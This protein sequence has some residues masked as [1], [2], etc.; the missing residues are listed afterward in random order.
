MGQDRRGLV[1]AR[2]N[3]SMLV[4]DISEVDKTSPAQLRREYEQQLAAA[5]DEIGFNTVAERT[6]ID[7]NTLSALQTGESPE[8]TVEEAAAIL[9]LTDAWPDAETL[10]LELRDSV[11]LRMSSAVMDV[12]TLS[13]AIDSNLGPTE[14]QQRIEGRHPMTLAEYAEVAYAIAE[15][16]HD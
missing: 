7:E 6:E 4:D 9:G 10:L 8:I 15:G 13:M 11:M 3:L 16:Q 1:S 5:I 14:L 12:D 2:R